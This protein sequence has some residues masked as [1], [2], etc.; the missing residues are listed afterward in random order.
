MFTGNLLCIVLV[1]LSNQ[2]YRPLPVLLCMHACV[3]GLCTW[4]CDDRFK[5]FV[6]PAAAAPDL[7]FCTLYTVNVRCVDELLSS[8]FAMLM[9]PTS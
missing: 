3:V 7:L 6:D 9:A 2:A 5:C 4:P 1:D 8:R